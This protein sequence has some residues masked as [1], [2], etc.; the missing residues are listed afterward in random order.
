MHQQQL[1]EAHRRIAGEDG[2]G[3]FSSEATAK[4]NYEAA[5]KQFHDAEAL[6]AAFAGPRGAETL[7]TLKAKFYDP[8]TWPAY[9]T[10]GEDQ[11]AYGYIREGQK[12]VIDQI[13]RAQQVVLLGPPPKPAEPE[14]TTN[15]ETVTP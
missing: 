15:K 3:A 7:A 2:W 5:L 11:R 8:P 6:C 1:N 10:N 9:L 12:S 4:Q 13:L 14:S